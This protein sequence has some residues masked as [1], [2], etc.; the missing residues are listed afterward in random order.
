MSSAM[1]LAPQARGQNFL[2]LASLSPYTHY[3]TFE[4]DHFKFVYQDGLFDFTQLAAKHLE[5]AHTILSPLLKWTPRSK[6]TVLIADNEDSANGFSAPALRIGLVLIATPPDAWMS[7]TYSE[8]WI[9][10]LVFHEYTHMLN[11]DAT[12]EWMEAVRILFGDVIRPNGLWPR[13]ML[14]GLAVYFETR[15]STLGRGRSPYYDSILRAF[16]LD[17]RLGNAKNFGIT[18]DRV[19]GDYPFFPAGETAYLFGYHLWNQFAQDQK[20]DEKMG[21]YSIRSS[22]RVPYFI[23][24]NLENVTGKNWID[25]WNQFI[26]ESNSRFGEQIEKIRKQGET[27]TTFITDSGYSAQGGVISNDGLKMAYTRT[28]KER[29]QGLYLRDLQTGKEKRITDKYS[30][31]GMSFTPDSRFLIFSS[32]VKFKTYALYSDLFLYDVQTDRLQTLTHGARAKDPSFSLDGKKV[33]YIV[34]SNASHFL[35]AAD[36]LIDTEGHATL[37]NEHDAYSAAPFS[38]MGSPRFINNEEIVFSLQQLGKPQSDLIIT[39]ANNSA[40]HVLLSDQ[41]MNRYPFLGRQNQ[42][43]YVSDLDGIENVYQIDADGNF[44]TKLT[45]VTTGANTPFFSPNGDLYASIMTSNGYEIAKLELQPAPQFKT[46]EVIATASAPTSLSDALQSPELKI[47]RDQVRDYSPWSSLLPRQWA[48]FYFGSANS[49]DGATV[50]GLILGFDSTGK[51]QYLAVANYHFKPKTFD[52]ELNYTLY[53]FRPLINL[54]ANSYTH[55]IGSGPNGDQYRRTYEAVAELA[56][57][58]QWTYSS[59]YPR[60]YGFLDWRSIYDLNTGARVASGDFEFSRPIIPGYGA[61]IGYA[62]LEQS[63]LGFMTEEGTE[64]SLT[65]EAR[66]NPANFTLY[67]YLAR[68]SQYIRTGD[69]SVLN[70]TLRWLGS[71]RTTGYERGY[72]LLQGKDTHD[73]SDRGGGSSLKRLELRGY[74]DM[75]ILTRSTGILSADFHFPID[76]IFSGLYNTFPLF[77]RQAHGFVFAETAYTPSPRFGDLFLPSFGAGINFDTTFL[78]QLPITISLEVQNGTRKDFGGDQLFFVSVSN[79][80]FF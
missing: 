31:I 76:E 42:I 33:T 45:N 7:T 3:Q 66:V 65:G 39:A 36:L 72:S 46:N 16:Y 48:P 50:G 35:K 69:H 71:S 55:D 70:P 60:L 25:Y 61:S 53:Y 80:G 23:E 20:N 21:E 79:A 10:L 14:E 75:T 58:I 26:S 74:S 62:K 51:Q 49:I 67:K 9:K 78:L 40:S 59:L 19:N 38:I 12:T 56:Y 52:F 5:H 73:L 44:K 18:L 11:I 30:G 43:I 28:S 13:W 41:K 4:T 17:H 54:S 27:K 2:E 64:L 24:W 47:D 8:D 68:A 6:T 29:R 77:F 37:S 32:L 63:R 1:S 15:T 22:H 34:D 57:P